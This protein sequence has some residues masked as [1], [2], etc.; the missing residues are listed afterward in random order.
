VQAAR[1]PQPLRLLCPQGA[2]AALAP[3]DLESLEHLVERP[4]ELGGLHPAAHDQALARPQKI[5]RAHS[6]DQPADRQ[7][8]VPEEQEVRGE[9]QQQPDS[10]ED[11]LDERDRGVDR[12]RRQ[13]E[14]QRRDHEQGGVDREDPPKQR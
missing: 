1:D 10:H 5:D 3:L 4:H 2:P 12:D 6:L 9:H 13:C 7:E 8:R 11:R 14:H